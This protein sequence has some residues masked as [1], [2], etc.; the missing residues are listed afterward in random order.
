MLLDEDKD[1]EA[2]C[3]LAKTKKII[4]KVLTPCS[5]V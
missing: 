2:D 5:N 3:F 1:L 4:C